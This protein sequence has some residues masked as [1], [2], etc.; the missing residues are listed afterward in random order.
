MSPG[1]SDADLFRVLSQ[2]MYANL[3]DPAIRAVLPQWLLQDPLRLGRAFELLVAR[4]RRESMPRCLLHGDAHLGNSYF[5]AD[6]SRIFIDFQLVTAGH[7]WR[8]L[9]Y[10]LVGSLSIE[11]RR[12]AERE[13]IEHYLER[14]AAH[15]A[16]GRLSFEKLW[17]EY[18]TWPVWGMVAWIGNLDKWGQATLPALER[19]YTAAADH[20]TLK[21][22]QA[23]LS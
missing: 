18:R 16:G 6:G 22:L 10:F 19:F 14:L 23:P 11:D 2:Y 1:A 17:D 5:R 12:S 21:R 8:D 4:E 20:E 13:L 9:T 15:G 7:A 3:E